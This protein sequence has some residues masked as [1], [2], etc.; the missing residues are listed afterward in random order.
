M[1]KNLTTAGLFWVAIACFVGG[2]GHQ[3]HYSHT[4]HVVPQ[5]QP[6]LQSV[7][8]D[9]PFDVQSV[10]EKV[11]YTA[12]GAESIEANSKSYLA[13]DK[14]PQP[15]AAVLLNVTGNAA[16]YI[17]I[18]KV[19]SSEFPVVLDEYAAGKYVFE[20]SGPGT[21]H[22]RSVDS[23][24][25]PVYAKFTIGDQ[26]PPPP[27]DPPVDP[28]PPPATD[29]AELRKIV[30]AKLPADPQTA[31]VLSTAYNGAAV[32]L[33]DSSKNYTLDEARKV[34]AAARASAFESLPPLKVDW[35]PFL[36]AA[37]TYMQSLTTIEQ[38]RTALIVLA[39]ELKKSKPSVSTTAIPQ[40]SVPLLATP[41]TAIWY[42]STP[43]TQWCPDGQC[44]T[45]T[46]QTFPRIFRR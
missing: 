8:F 18:T 28:Q 24:G 9:P 45:P 40:A 46:Y 12:T 43:Q 4:S 16:K 37:G 20:H 35:N 23:R 44:P 7:I 21:Y 36:L 14:A 31:I 42:E 1:K 27:V 25:R 5:D 41:P 39:E 13:F 32:G 29:H 10:K 33:S 34:V 11:L 3:S 15:V 22:V 19:G 30:Q 38:Y 2:M 26:P 6:A 17:E